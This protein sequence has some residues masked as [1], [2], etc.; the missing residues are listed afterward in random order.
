MYREDPSVIITPVLHAIT[1][2]E[3]V[4]IPYPMSKH[5]RSIGCKRPFKAIARR[6]VTNTQNDFVDEGGEVDEGSDVDEGGDVDESE[7]IGRNV[8][9][10]HE[11]LFHFFCGQIFNHGRFIWRIRSPQKNLIVM[12]SYD[13]Q[14][15]DFQV[16]FLS[17]FL[18]LLVI[19][20]AY[21]SVYDFE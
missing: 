1:G 6:S 15:G 13:S 19:Y 20:F 18:L 7:K 12:N 17:F 14:T 8:A 2:V 10:Y 16:Y 4:T 3:E 21:L 5:H 11:G 9:S